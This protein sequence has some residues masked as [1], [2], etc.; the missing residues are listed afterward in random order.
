MVLVTE[1]PMLEPMMIGMAEV[2]SN[3]G[4]RGASQMALPYNNFYQAHDCVLACLSK[5]LTL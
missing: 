1:V 2:T 5:L 3:T 4:G